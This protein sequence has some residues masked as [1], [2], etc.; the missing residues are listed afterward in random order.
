MSTAL[1][2]LEIT[3]N[4]FLFIVANLVL[5]F[6]LQSTDDLESPELVFYLFSSL[7]SW[8]EHPSAAMV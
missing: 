7:T 8:W 6:L 4:V 2:E 1:G 3:N 5:N